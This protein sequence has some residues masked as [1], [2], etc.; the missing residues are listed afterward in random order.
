M[1]NGGA[2]YNVTLPTQTVSSGGTRGAPAWD[3]SDA[4]YVSVDVSVTTAPGVQIGVEMTET[5]TSFKALAFYTSGTGVVV[6]S[7][8]FVLVIPNVGFKQMAI[9]TSAASTGGITATGVKHV[10]V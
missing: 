9:L 2:S 7:S 8:S 5:G 4:V 10:R 3:V 6:S 1:P